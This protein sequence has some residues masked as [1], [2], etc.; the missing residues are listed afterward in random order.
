M[1]MLYLVEVSVCVCVCVN[2]S[3]MSNSCDPMD[4]S[5]PGSSV[6]GI[7]QARIL[8]WVAIPFSKS[9]YMGKK[10]DSW[11]GF[12]INIH[13]VMTICKIE[14][15]LIES[16]CEI[17]YCCEKGI[18]KFH[19]KNVIILGSLTEIMKRGMKE[20]LSGI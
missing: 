10:K 5:L 20:F 13:T 17:C 7:L 16:T 4:C 19:L 3:V 1:Y 9:Q 11:S 8:E 14:C 18:Q 12:F 6:R 15:F 2:H